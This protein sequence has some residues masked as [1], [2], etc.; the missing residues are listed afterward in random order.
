MSELIVVG[1]RE[2][3]RASQV[4]DALGTA[5]P[6]L[7]VDLDNGVVVRCYPDGELRVQIRIDP[8]DSA[9]AR[10]SSLWGSLISTALLQPLTD[11]VVR[12]AQVAGGGD[13]APP[14]DQEVAYDGEGR[15]YWW[16]NTLAL[17][18]SFVRDIGA[19]I[20]PGTS[21]LILLLR[22]AGPQGVTDQLPVQGGT[23]L[24]LPL[25]R[26]QDDE[27][28]A[29]LQHTTPRGRGRMAPMAGVASG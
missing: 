5:L 12:A 23:L 13:A 26:R 11:E 19:L 16:L 18:A 3:C 9:G 20:R 21:V 8:T 29:I 1:Y 2:P 27:L 7:V 4:L 15:D 22:S 25:S 10:W 6:G 17:P 28:T 24:H 14:I